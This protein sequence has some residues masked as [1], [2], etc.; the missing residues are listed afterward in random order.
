M[1]SKKWLCMFGAAIVLAL[2]VCAAFN[3]LVDPFGAFGDPV[4]KWYGYD[5]TNNPRVAKLSWLKEHSQDYDSYVIGSSSAASYN[6]E[7]LNDYLDAKFYNLFVYGCDTRD[8][9]DFAA[10]LMENCE[11]KNLVLN[12][13]LNEATLYD[14]GEDSIND[15]MH[16]AAS[17]RSMLQFYL[18][19]AFCNP[20]LSADK[21]L[22][23]LRDEELPRYFDVF[24]PLS[25]CYDKRLRDIEKIGDP[26]VYEAAHGEDFAFTP[27]EAQLPYIRECAQSVAAIRDLCD[28]K[29]VNLIV[30]TSP[31]YYGQW[32][33]YSE[34]ALRAY[35]AA[36]AEEV[37]FWDFSYT[38][39][40]YDSRYF[41]DS[42]HFRNA[43]GTM[44]LAEIFGNEA[45]YRPQRFGAYVTAENCQ[46][47]MDL[48]F[49][50]PPVPDPA[51]YTVDVPILLYHHVVEELGDGTDDSV[52]SLETLDRQLRLLAEE[53]YHAVTSRE[54]ID[55]V[56]H[57][58]SLPDKPVF[59]TFDDGYYSNYSL[60]RPLLEKYGLTATVFS[61]GTSMGHMEYYKDTQ[62]P[63]TPHFGYEEAREMR[64]TG[65]IDIQ[66]HTYDMHQWPPFETSGQVRGNIL[67]LEGE[68]YQAYA[69]ALRSDLET[70]NQER[71]QELGAPFCALAY[72]EGRYCDWTE[73]LVHQSGIPL[74]LSTRTDSRNVLVRGLPQSLYALCRWYVTENTTPE[75]LRAILQNT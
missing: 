52:I 26:D 68:S 69:E 41:Y 21:L 66:S 73:V 70:Y 23:R 50:D 20:R 75:Q 43:L 40:S 14:I 28:R 17:G 30:I 34:D 29:G 35:K 15:R 72:P 10:W 67:P 57:G 22:A 62:H 53:G 31:V 8:Y 58:G 71:E 19:Y 44:V 16:A 24:E 51:D 27:G 59:I 36:L 54:L 46:S 55:Y 49:S 61:I 9:V 32:S 37:E 39:A 64:Q 4:M 25:G 13:G 56:Y 1:S 63:I 3:I 12:L 33:L 18:E 74:T 65:V 5:E 7:E 45:V 2:A 42:T 38:P 48:L 47:H 60:A 6:V 11:V